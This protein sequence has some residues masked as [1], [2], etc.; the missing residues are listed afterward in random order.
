[1]TD[2]PVAVI[3][4]LVVASAY[5][6]ISDTSRGRSVADEVTALAATGR[7]RPR[8]VTFDEIR[9]GEQPV[10]DR[11]TAR[12]RSA[13]G[14]A[15]EDHPDLWASRAW[16]VDPA[17]L[18]ARLPF[19]DPVPADAKAARGVD[20]RA[21]SLDALGRRLGRG[22]RRLVHA[23]GSDPAGIAAAELAAHIRAPL[24]VTEQWNRLEARLANRGRLAAARQLA[25]RAAWIVA[26]DDEMAALLAA[27]LPE[28]AGRIAVIPR[29]V[30]M[31]RFSPRSP[32]ER[33]PYEV[34]HVGLRSEV[35]GIDTL[36]VG[37]ARAHAERPLL[38]LRLV[39]RSPTPAFDRRWRARVVELGIGDAVSFEGQMLR[40]GIAEVLSRAALVVHAGRA[41][42]FGTVPIEALASGTPVVATATP[43]AVRVFGERPETL[44]ALVPLDDG[45][46]LGQAIVTTLDRRSELDP[47]RLRAA[48]ASRFDA[49]TLADRLVQLY[50]S[51]LDQDPSAAA[52]DGHVPS[53]AG[54]DGPAI[55]QADELPIVVAS[56]ARRAVSIVEPLPET[57][58]SRLRLVTRAGAADLPPLLGGLARLTTARRKTARRGRVH[59][60]VETLLHPVQAIR[61]YRGDTTPAGRLRTTVQREARRQGPPADVLAVDAVDLG[62]VAPLAR[63]RRV[64]LVPGGADW[65]GDRTLAIPAADETPPPTTGSGPHI[66]FYSPADMNVLD[67]SA[68]WTESTAAILAS[69]PG[70]SVA[71]V[72]RAPEMRDVVTRRVRSIPGVR[73]I[74]PT[75]PIG[76]SRGRLTNGE[77]LDLLE[78]LD[79]ADPFDIVVLRGYEVCRLAAERG[80]FD[81]RLVSAYILEPERDRE[82]SAYRSD[83]SRIALGSRRVAV[84]SDAMAALLTE[85]APEAADRTLLLPPGIPPRSIAP[86]PAPSARRLIYAGK[87]HPFY[88]IDEL[89]DGFVELR[90]ARPGLE[91]HLVGDKLMASP[92]DPEFRSRI[93]SRLEGTPGVVWHGGID[94]DALNR[95]FREGGVALSVWDH[96]HGAEMND[97]VVS[98]K[99]LDYCA[100]GLPVVLTRTRMQTQLLGPDYPFFIDQPREARSAIARALDDPASASAASRLALAAAARYSYDTLAAVV[101]TELTLGTRQPVAAG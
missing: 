18:V 5:P 19:V 28:A 76:D 16:S 29:G 67:G 59:R 98:T 82:S 62:A 42:A 92:G 58:V 27:R 72:L 78:G 34:V 13:L 2:R 53:P 36:L 57:A 45:A 35:K 96:R 75:G 71:V 33:R 20:A 95:L 94:R 93:R 22:A 24:V 88:A 7:V 84:Q 63:R 80:T 15:I 47:A 41:E 21:A 90:A 81:G 46:A 1:V 61:R 60:L 55:Q 43:T 77:A 101:A 10:D 44:G 25:A 68:I 32:A 30:D 85:L 3:D 51:I 69:I 86:G 74:R 52:G 26:L 4:L 64:R 97:L 70:A 99:L 89:L 73:A 65:L 12:L 48:V 11:Q 38:K 31:D 39:G 49:G 87:F 14:K 37:F 17:I 9:V 8:V 23:H 40:S 100:A 54:D 56:D 91:F 79:R 66:G 50:G 83:L 6:G